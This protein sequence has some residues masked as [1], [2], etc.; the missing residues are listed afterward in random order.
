LRLDSFLERLEHTHRSGNGY[1]A[2]CPSHEDLVTSLC[3][4]ENGDKLLVHCQAGCATESV[5]E[6]MGLT[7]RDLFYDSFREE[8]EAVYEYTN[9][10]GELL[11]E[12]LRFPGKKFKQRRCDPETR[13]LIWGLDGTHR[14]L[15]RLPEV[16]Y[17]VEH[18]HTVYVCEGEKDVEALRAVNK[19]AT[20][21]SGGVGSWKPDY[22]DYL[23]G[24]RVIIVADK[25]EPGLKHAADVARSLDG[26]ALSVHVVQAKTGKDA[27]DHLAAG[28]TVEEFVQIV[29]GDTRRHYQPLDLFQP[30]PEVNWIVTDVLVGGEATLLV[31]DGGA[32]KSFF[33]L[34]LSL[35]VASGEP[36]LDRAVKQGRV[37]YCDEEG[38]PDLALQRLAQLGAT[39]EQKANLDYLNF[40]GVDM[41][42]HPEKLIEDAK[43]VQPVLVVIDSHAKV[44]RLGEENSNN[45]M[46][47]AWDDGFLKLARDTGAAV[48]VIHHTRKDGDTRGA[49]QIRN[50]ADQALTMSKQ[51]DGSQ[52]VWPSKPRRLTN[53]IHFEFQDCGD[54]RYALVPYGSQSV[55]PAE[56]DEWSYQ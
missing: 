18:G 24:A 20:C 21:N 39:D 7:M 1:E 33:A 6:A 48:L 2:R 51:A 35:A 26:I 44:T 45:E 36:F 25:D 41:V 14:V 23:R 3:V 8:P 37:I 4:A 43:L 42:R 46:G 38:S 56:Y 9:E 10:N 11:Y 50:S 15:Y 27:A 31:A 54:G 28:H 30:V 40:A 32:G 49:S 34:A 13:E 19:I 12:V 22:S 16:V 52:V 55:Q 17:A 47:K 53:R 5:V 29:L